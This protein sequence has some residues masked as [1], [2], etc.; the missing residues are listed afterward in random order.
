MTKVYIVEFCTGEYEDQRDEIHLATFNK[1]RAEKEVAKMNQ[2]LI[3]N[4]MHDTS[5]HVKSGPVPG[6]TLTVDYTG[7]DFYMYE[8][9]VED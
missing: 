6:T 1:D 8:I 3:D 7:G 5:I 4:A 2:V 9:E